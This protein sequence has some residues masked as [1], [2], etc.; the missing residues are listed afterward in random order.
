MSILAN[1]IHAGRSLGYQPKF[2]A[3]AW[4]LGWVGYRNLGDEALYDAL[5]KLFHPVRFIPC[6]DDQTSYQLANA[7]ERC[8]AILGGGTL[9]GERRSLSRLQRVMPLAKRTIVFGTGIEEPSFW[10]GRNPQRYDLAAWKPVLERCDYIGVRGPRSQSYLQQIG[11][12]S[13]IIGDPACRFVQ[14]ATKLPKEN[15]HLGLN[16]GTGSSGMFSDD[17]TVLATLSLFAKKML[18]DGWRITLYVVW[19]KDLSITKAFAAEVGIPRS[20]IYRVYRNPAKFISAVRRHSLFVG[21][22]LHSVVLS[23]CAGV[24]SF[25]IEYR[26]KCRDFMESIGAEDFVTRADQLSLDHLL[27]KV[28][29]LRQDGANLIKRT[30]ARL[31]FFRDKQIATAQRVLSGV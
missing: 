14:P 27:S 16:I 4:Y 19:P 18:A 3:T 25:M 23:F 12:S 31:Q 5:R 8:F 17:Q 1:W 24:P 15:R 10:V 26:P 30:T 13:E 21:F 6:T 11:I 9:L 2:A 7:P 20:S 29:L 28:D 22:K